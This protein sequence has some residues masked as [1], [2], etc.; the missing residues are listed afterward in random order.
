[1]RH[2]K[3][4]PKKFTLILIITAIYIVM[5]LSGKDNWIGSVIYSIVV[6]GFVMTMFISSSE[7]EEL[8]D[9]IDHE[10]KRLNMSREKLYAVTGCN[11]FEVSDNE[12]GKTIFWVTKSRKKDVLKKLRHLEA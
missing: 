10:V 9:Q 1:M 3:M 5:N 11:R 8:N 4:H 6:I 2:I 7:E 12:Q